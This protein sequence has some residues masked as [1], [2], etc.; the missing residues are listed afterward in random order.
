MLSLITLRCYY[1]FFEF[2]QSRQRQCIV[3]N[4]RVLGDEFSVLAH[5]AKNSATWTSGA[6]TYGF[7]V[8]EPISTKL[9]RTWAHNAAA[10]LPEM[11]EDLWE[12]QDEKGTAVE[13]ARI[14]LQEL[15]EELFLAPLLSLHLKGL[16]RLRE[17]PSPKIP[18]RTASE[19][20]RSVK[21]K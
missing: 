15:P 4:F 16:L 5:S 7:H 11:N 1:L 13:L 19:D 14:E 12:H 21:C 18:G 20:V 17:F 9:I 2:G 6:Y 8:S 10:D 3:E